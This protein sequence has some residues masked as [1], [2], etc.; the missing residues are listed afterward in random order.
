M[1]LFSVGTGRVF[2]GSIGATVGPTVST[3][4][5]TKPIVVTLLPF[6][7]LPECDK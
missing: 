6:I 5:Q 7:L 1:T 2:T 3:T 4:T